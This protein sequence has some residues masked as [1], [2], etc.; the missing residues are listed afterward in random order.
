MEYRYWATT[1]VGRKRKN[2]E[3]NFLIDKDLRLFV[4][5]RL[6]L[7]W[8]L[9]FPLKQREADE[10]GID[11]DDPTQVVWRRF[12]GNTAQHFVDDRQQ[13]QIMFQCQVEI[14]N[15]LGFDALGCIDDD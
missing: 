15:G 8:S 13:F 4:R 12:A 5:D 1:D 14:G 2:N 6:A 7:F 9:A 10:E 11:V 3:D